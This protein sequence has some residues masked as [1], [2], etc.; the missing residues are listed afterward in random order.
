MSSP[1]TSHHAYMYTRI[2]T[3]HIIT[4]H[5]PRILLMQVTTMRTLNVGVEG[6]AIQLAQSMTSSSFATII[7]RL[8]YDLQSM[9]SSSFAAAIDRFSKDLQS[10][11]SSSFAAVI[12][13][14]FKAVEEPDEAL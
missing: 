7:D 12:D 10:M 13:R 2:Y 4:P 11:T 1:V 6:M 9:T 14:L 5:P 3:T 8:S